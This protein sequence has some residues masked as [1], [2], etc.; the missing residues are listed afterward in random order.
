M[1]RVM[2]G[3]SGPLYGCSRS[4]C[5]AQSNEAAVP[6]PSQMKQH[7]PVP[8]TASDPSS[9]SHDRQRKAGSDRT[10]GGADPTAIYWPSNELPR[11]AACSDFPKVRFSYPQNRF[12]GL[13]QEILFCSIVS[14]S[15]RYLSI[16]QPGGW[17]HHSKIGRY[18][19]D[20]V[21]TH[22]KKKT[23]NAA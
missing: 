10:V 13:T 3:G 7:S 9:L 6:S 19:Y 16:F 21:G 15:T 11:L 4:L 23:R 17:N 8:C 5:H 12:K 20:L 22:I 1:M 18:R 14:L 2:R